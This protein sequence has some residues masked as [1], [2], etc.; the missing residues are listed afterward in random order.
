MLE[1]SRFCKAI[2]LSLIVLSLFACQTT[3]T[4]P[5]SNR[6]K[7]PNEIS[8]NGN[9][10]IL[11]IL[12]LADGSVGDIK[13]LE[14]SGDKSI[15]DAAVDFY[16]ERARFIPAKKDGK[17]VDSWKTLAVRFATKNELINEKK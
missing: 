14:S 3:E 1:A 13:V 15:D 8:S 2:Y 16:R 17:P 10:T 6:A 5:S 9:K 11:S 4:A 12:V 7:I